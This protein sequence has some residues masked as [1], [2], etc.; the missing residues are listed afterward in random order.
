[1]MHIRIAALLSGIGIDCAIVSAAD[2]DSS[3]SC[4]DYGHDL[5]HDDA[6]QLC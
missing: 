2:D 3:S 6:T 1:M 5:S 4:S